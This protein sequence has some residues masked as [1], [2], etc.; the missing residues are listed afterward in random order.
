MPRPHSFRPTILVLDGG[1]Y[2]ITTWNET[3]LTA[4]RLHG[5][6]E[7]L[8]VRMLRSIHLEID[9]LIRASRVGK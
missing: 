6:E 8:A 7:A 5:D 3:R 4:E 1:I 9:A 2:R